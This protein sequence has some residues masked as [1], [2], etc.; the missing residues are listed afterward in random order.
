MSPRP[1]ALPY[2]ST[3][4]TPLPTHPS[5]PASLRLAMKNATLTVT[6]L[7]MLDRS[8]VQ[9]LQLKALDTVLFG[10]PLSESSARPERSSTV[11]PTQKN[12]RLHQH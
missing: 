2:I 8:H 10:P 12:L 11:R 5:A 6:V 3:L 9:K 4:S 7:K 1:P